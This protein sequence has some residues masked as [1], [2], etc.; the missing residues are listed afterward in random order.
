MEIKKLLKKGL[1]LSL[2]FTMVAQ[3]NAQF[4]TSVYAEEET[5]VVVSEESSED[6]TTTTDDTTTVDET[7]TTEDQT[8]EEQVDED[9]EEE[10]VEEEVKE[11]AHNATAY[12]LGQDVTISQFT[13]S[14]TNG[15]NT[16]SFKAYQA[17][18]GTVTYDPDN[19]WF[20]DANKLDKDKTTNFTLN[21][22]YDP[23]ANGITLG[24]GDT[25][26]MTIPT[27]VIKP[28]AVPNSTDPGIITEVGTGT[29]I[30]TY[31]LTE[32]GALTISFDATYLKNH[33]GQ[34]TNCQTTC[35]GTLQSTVTPGQKYPDVFGPF[36]I[37]FPVK[38][39]ET[40]THRGYSIAK[41]VYNELKGKYDS[42]A[43]LQQD[44]KGLYSQYK[45]T[46]TADSSNTSDL[47]LTALVIRDWM[48][49][50]SGINSDDATSC[51]KEY[52]DITVT[53]DGKAVD[54]SLYTAGMESYKS[55]KEHPNSF[56]VHFNSGATLAKGKSVVVTYK[57]YYN[58]NFQTNKYYYNYDCVY[59][60]GAWV[61]KQAQ[62]SVINREKLQ[63][64]KDSGN[65][66]YNSTDKHWYI[67]YTLTVWGGNSQS[68]D[69][70]KNANSFDV[71]NVTIT[72]TI[73][74]GSDYID[75]VISVSNDGIYDKNNH[76]ITWTNQK[77]EKDKT[78]DSP[79]TYTYTVRLK[80][81]ALLQTGSD[82]SAKVE[83]KNGVD[84]TAE[85]VTPGHDDHIATIQKY[86]V[87]KGGEQQQNGTV[88]FSYT[89]NE[90]DTTDNTQ[91]ASDK[92]FNYQDKLGKGWLYCDS[93]GN[94]SGNI[95]I[96]RSS[97]GGKTWSN[98]LAIPVYSD[99]SDIFGD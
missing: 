41:T 35:Y 29:Q 38:E 7:T 16:Y 66:Y 72:D 58:E 96:C 55:Q 15:S 12:V 65:Y 25:L 95:T 36:E 71:E 79:K 84:I 75:D 60:D 51:I 44:S 3:N 82:G 8:E 50:A 6:D 80:D 43:H 53:I 22:K 67:D 27:D 2:A 85:G 26:T 40:V 24:E 9:T 33:G 49:S 1:A 39:K 30:G 14:C 62:V 23:N 69:G 74:S 32:V 97:D 52:A 34:I 90:V 17:V 89:A 64:K 88:K 86:W 81:E 92:N 31:T 10:V 73:Q 4:F 56:A 11:E 98:R 47:D 13:M 28:T 57:V 63:V 83:I 91:Y 19:N 61:N 37:D 54:S 78:E 68:S 99:V 87:K 76:T 42:S 21:F 94:D 70:N 18:D 45:L 59:D 48:T 20:S 77:V 5:P 46:L 93:N